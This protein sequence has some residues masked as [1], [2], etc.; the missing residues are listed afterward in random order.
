MNLLYEKI[1]KLEYHQKLLLQIIEHP[2]KAFDKLVVEC[3]LGEKEV[4]EFGRLCENMINEWEKQ[5]AEGFVHYY[6]L[7]QK[8]ND[9]LHHR[10]QPEKVINA[11][12]KQRLF[13]PLMEEF[14]KYL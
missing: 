4:K 14:K 2:Y 5:K 10:F 11:C 12:I 6:P 3:S 13:L 1:K 9:Q 7:F 8:F